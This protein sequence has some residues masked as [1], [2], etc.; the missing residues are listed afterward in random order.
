MTQH[1]S[2]GSIPPWPRPG[3]RR[4][5][6]WEFAGGGC[7]LAAPYKYPGCPESMFPTRCNGLVAPRRQSVRLP[8]TCG[9]NLLRLVSRNHI[10]FQSGLRALDPDHAVSSGG[11]TG[12]A[13]TRRGG[14][15]PSQ[16]A[17]LQVRFLPRPLLLLALD[18]GQ[19]KMGAMSG[20]AVHTAP[21][22]YP[23]CP[24]SMLPTKWNG[25]VAPRRQSVRSVG[26]AETTAPP[27]AAART[28]GLA[29]APTANNSGG[30]AAGQQTAQKSRW[31]REAGERHARW[32]NEATYVVCP[33]RAVRAGLGAQK[34]W[35]ISGNHIGFQSGLRTLDP[36][37]A[38]SSGGPTGRARTRR[39]GV[40]PSRRA[41]LQ[42]RLLPRP[43]LV[44][45]PD[46][47]AP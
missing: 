38:L 39:G 11:P 5:R 24:L 18:W 44:A 8:P 21:S 2:V 37:H 19:V 33:P 45:G 29:S 25:L 40:R 42:V 9:G 23:G 26:K 4:V 7:V 35:R 31:R 34:H 10:G 12:R 32:R 47:T 1:R 27:A 3:F 36:D 13:R 41:W 43:L 16:R 17:W 20:Q 15:R 28:L 6:G 14:V 30:P 46:G 22:K